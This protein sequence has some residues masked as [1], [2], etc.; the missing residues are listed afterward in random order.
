MFLCICTKANISAK[1]FVEKNERESRF[2]KDKKVE[3]FEKKRYLHK[4]YLNCTYNQV[5][6]NIICIKG[7][8]YIA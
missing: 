5:Y 3:N 2:V 6:K 8:V 7:S 1:N 4:N